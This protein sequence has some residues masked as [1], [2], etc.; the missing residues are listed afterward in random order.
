MKPE[1]RAASEAKPWSGDEH[2]PVGSPYLGLV[3][4]R[5][6]DEVNG[7]GRA[8]VQNHGEFRSDADARVPLKKISGRSTR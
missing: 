4:L 7:V 2:P 6:A 1:D 8:D 5:R 3:R